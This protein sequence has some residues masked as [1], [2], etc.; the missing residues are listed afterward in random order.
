MPG[1]YVTA[2]IVAGSALVTQ[3]IARVR[4]IYR[5]ENGIVSGCT[6]SKLEHTDEHE[7]DCQKYDLHGHEVLVVS[8]KS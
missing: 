4:C 7:I 1:E 5:K 3:C 6:D 2:G 8:A